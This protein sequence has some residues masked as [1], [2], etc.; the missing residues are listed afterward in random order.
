MNIN[1]IKRNINKKT[2]FNAPDE[3]QE[4]KQ[5]KPTQE[6]P[7]KARENRTVN[8]LFNPSDDEEEVKPQSEAWDTDKETIDIH[9]EVSKTIEELELSEIKYDWR[10]TTAK[11]RRS[12]KNFTIYLK[13]AI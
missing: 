8:K 3:I 11:G 4:I 13:N 7:K 9:Q 5:E 12:R 1:E 2:N 10:T 6:K